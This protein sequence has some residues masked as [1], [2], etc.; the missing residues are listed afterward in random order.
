MPLLVFKQNSFRKQRENRRF[1]IRMEIPVE[2]LEI[3]VSKACGK[4]VFNITNST[5]K[6]TM[7][8][9]DLYDQGTMTSVGV[10]KV[11]LVSV[12]VPVFL[13][14]IVGNVFVLLAILLDHRMR[15]S[16]ANF[17]LVNM[18]IADLLGASCHFLSFFLFYTFPSFLNSGCFLGF[19]HF[20]CFKRKDF[21]A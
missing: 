20:F 21:S 7:S 6:P 15:K 17:L 18:A 3:D 16:A 10:G 12:Y 4:E 9:G 11:L 19:F 1:C 2:V 5:L 8:A 14:A 13:I